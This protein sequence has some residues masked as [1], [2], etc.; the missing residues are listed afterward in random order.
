ML[1]YN[2]RLEA[3]L[4]QLNHER[5]NRPRELLDRLR[6][7]MGDEGLRAFLAWLLAGRR[8]YLEAQ[9]T[10]ASEDAAALD[11]LPEDI[12]EEPGQ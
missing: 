4:D 11:T 2:S 10:Q 6:Q 1:N 7:G 3:A 12:E 9:S 8:A 5:A